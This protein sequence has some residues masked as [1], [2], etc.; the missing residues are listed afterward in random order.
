MAAA[1]SRATASASGLQ[2]LH[3]HA[4]DVTPH[5]PMRSNG[6][7]YHARVCVD[8][9]H[10]KRHP[11]TRRA[12]VQGSS[13]RASGRR[14]TRRSSSMTLAAFSPTRR[15]PCQ[16][17]RTF[18]RSA[19][20][21][22]RSA[23]RATRGRKTRADRGLRLRRCACS[24]LASSSRTN[25]SRKQSNLRTDRESSRPSTKVN[26]AAQYVRHAGRVRFAHRR[27]YMFCSHSEPCESCSC[28][29]CYPSVSVWHMAVRMP[30]L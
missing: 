9:V 21:P 22:P 16:S 24:P 7:I 25:P 1:R 26:E 3:T 18:S 27:R 30:R 20:Q 6:A 28:H 17:T 13:R 10:R 23:A 19:T 11:L 15:S 14:S 12:I 8:A 29:R 2:H 4:V 5:L